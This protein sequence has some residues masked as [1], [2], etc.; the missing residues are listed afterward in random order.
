M[1]PIFPFLWVTGKTHDFSKEIQAIQDAGIQSFCV[2][3]RVHQDFC[4]E[5]WWQDF[6]NILQNAKKRNM[7]VWI[8]DDKHYPTG[9]ANEKLA[10]YPHLQA[11]FLVCD[12]FDIATDGNG[13][14]LCVCK[15][16]GDCLLSA[17]AIPY[18]DGALQFTKRLILKTC[19]VAKLRENF[20]L[21]SYFSFLIIFA[22]ANLD[23]D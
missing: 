20:Y 7:S 15:E 21:S 4:Q 18:S 12:H 9:N 13:I 14:Q 8:L 17:I 3:S 10:L 22:L 1:Q 19:E 16:E 6:D 2:E 23:L 5:A 11:N